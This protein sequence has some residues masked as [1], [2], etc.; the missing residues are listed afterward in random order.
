MH[1]NEPLHLPLLA[2]R[3][4]M[5]PCQLMIALMPAQVV[6]SGE[7]LSTALKRASQALSAT[8]ASRHFCFV[9]SEGSLGYQYRSRLSGG[10]GMVRDGDSVR[11]GFD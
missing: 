5:R 2:Y 9:S 3:T 10:R 8:P 6:L 11:V 1:M 4:D 7:A